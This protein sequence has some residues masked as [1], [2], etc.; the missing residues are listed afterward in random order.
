MTTLRV[1]RRNLPAAGGGWMRLLPPTVMRRAIRAANKDGN[2]AIVY[3]HPWEVD[4]DQPRMPDAS[5]AARFRHTVNLG[6]MEARLERLLQ[7][8]SFDTVSSVLEGLRDR[9]DE[10]DEASLTAVMEKTA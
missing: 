7:S 8:F 4:P 6:G 10:L 3:L 5:R 2:P 1:L 9:A